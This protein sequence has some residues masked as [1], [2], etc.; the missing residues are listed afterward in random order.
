MDTLHAPKTTAPELAGDAGPWEMLKKQTQA[1]ATTT[2]RYKWQRVLEAFVAGR[3]YNRFE[4]EWSLHDHC[5]HSTVS[6]LQDMGIVI[7]RESET[8]RGYQGNPT[9]VKRYWLAPASRM[10]AL[11]LL[12]R[13][14][15][16][17]TLPDAIEGDTGVSDAITEAR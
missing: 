10:R 5:L 11:A 6:T 13:L 4:A 3:T 9:V 15:P 16:G 8:V 2:P 1:H 12:G 17:A 7:H 14:P